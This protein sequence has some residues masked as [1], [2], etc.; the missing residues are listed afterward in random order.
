MA[1]RLWDTIV[2]R[3]SAPPLAL[4]IHAALVAAAAVAIVD[5][6]RSGW[7][8]GPAFVVIV[9]W[10][11]LRGSR[12]VWWVQVVA[13]FSAAAQALDARD[14]VRHGSD[15]L[16]V[17]F[18]ES[19]L[20][21][22]AATLTLAW[23]LLLLP[24]VRRYCRDDPRAPRGSIWLAVAVLT[25]TGFPTMAL[26][27]DSWMPAAQ[28]ATRGVFV[29]G[30]REHRVAFYVEERS[31]EVCWS[32]L[33]IDGATNSCTGKKQLA[34]YPYPFAAQGFV[35]DVVPD[36]V[37]AVDVTFRSG[38]RKATVIDSAL[39][40]TNVYYVAG[41]PSHEWLRAVGYDRFGTEVYRAEKP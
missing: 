18:D 23:V 30:N 7:W 9:L 25:L 2:A 19:T 11:L 35:A 24:S 17:F 37:V 34:R 16:G 40:R 22:L 32:I 21:L 33:W 36:R 41:M 13:V 5:P 26:G 31:G 38:T 14:R 28:N 27:V 6:E 20:L 29:G 15:G 12:L 39:V 8:A 4:K 3:L 10:P 1:A